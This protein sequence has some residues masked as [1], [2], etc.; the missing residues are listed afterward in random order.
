M[1]KLRAALVSEMGT[2]VW[3]AL[4]F[5]IIGI[6]A[7]TCDRQVSR[8]DQH[9]AQ[10]HELERFISSEFVKK[11]ELC[12][13]KTDVKNIKNSLNNELPEIKFFMGQVTE[14]MRVQKK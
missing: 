4:I 2:I 12:D 10:I 9:D 5:L 13:L 14:Y 7:W 11:V 3:R 1:E 6:S 8:I